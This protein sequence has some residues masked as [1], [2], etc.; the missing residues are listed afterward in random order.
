MKSLSS[1][2]LF[3]LTLPS[4]DA[5]VSMVET[6]TQI[7]LNSSLEYSNFM[8]EIISHEFSLNDSVSFGILNLFFLII[9]QCK[10]P[11]STHELAENS[12]HGECMDYRIAEARYLII[13]CQIILL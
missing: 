3:S 10:L 9:N 1:M 5:Y 2:V 6:L 11:I 8:N 4:T 13:L 12:D 7:I